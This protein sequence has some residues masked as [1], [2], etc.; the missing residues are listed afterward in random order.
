MK[1]YVIWQEV[2]KCYLGSGSPTPAIGYWQCHSAHNMERQLPTAR[3]NSS[4]TGV[5]MAALQYSLA[6][7]QRG[8]TGQDMP[9]NRN[10]P[11]TELLQTKGFLTFSQTLSFM[12][13][14]PWNTSLDKTLSFR[15]G[16]CVG[17]MTS[18]WMY[19]NTAVY[20]HIFTSEIYELQSVMTDEN[21]LPGN[22]SNPLKGNSTTPQCWG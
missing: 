5:S 3:I 15:L 10:P 4:C 16:L 2:N 21:I 19:F 12:K 6:L 9:D 8:L 22:V 11:I 1:C 14:I 13:S 20:I 7:A 18:V 17:G